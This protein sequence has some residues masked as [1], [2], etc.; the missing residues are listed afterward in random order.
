VSQV[1]ERFHSLSQGQGPFTDLYS[2]AVRARDSVAG[3][4]FL[5][6][7]RMALELSK[8]LRLSLAGDLR[9]LQTSSLGAL[10]GE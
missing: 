10:E 8:A 6:G 3:S 4:N 7:L 5:D 9:M 2:N 1:I